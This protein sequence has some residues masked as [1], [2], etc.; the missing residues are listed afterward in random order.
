MSVNVLL[1]AMC[2][3]AVGNL[4]DHSLPWALVKLAFALAMF[5]VLVR[6]ARREAA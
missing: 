5:A 1:A 4:P 3:F 6:L 2:G